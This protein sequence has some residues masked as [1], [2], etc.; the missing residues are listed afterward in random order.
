MQTYITCRTNLWR[1]CLEQVSFPKAELNFF[2]VFYSKNKANPSTCW[3]LYVEWM[4]EWMKAQWK[5][6][7]IISN[8]IK[9]NVYIRQRST[10]NHLNII[11]KYKQEI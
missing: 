10:A 6:H 1:S 5:N 8:E 4:G 7:E 3:L 2:C 11:L 9:I